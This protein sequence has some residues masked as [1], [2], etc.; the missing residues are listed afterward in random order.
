[1]SF[2]LLTIFII[3]VILG[4]L[5]LI[6]ATIIIQPIRESLVES[7]GIRLIDQR[8]LSAFLGTIAELISR[9]ILPVI[10]FVVIGILALL[11]VG[12]PFSLDIQL[13]SSI[14]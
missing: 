9:F 6:G 11:V 3:L 2:N 7:T 14:V 5:G 13:G 8:Y 12:L 10:P 4:S 1:M